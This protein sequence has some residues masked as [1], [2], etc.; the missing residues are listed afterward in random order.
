VYA[1]GDVAN[2]LHPVFGRIRVEHYNNGEKMARAAARSMLD[3]SKPYG[4][5]HSFWSDQFETKLEYTGHAASWDRFVVRGSLEERKLVG[6]YLQDG[7]L[8]AAVGLDRGGD[9]ELEPES[10]LAACAGLVAA[11]ARV[12]EAALADESV[13]LES[14]L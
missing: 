12:S 7:V 10:E 11:Q 3:Q 6:F 1:A 13:D 4:Y 9:P 2:H 5:I 14:L 8:R